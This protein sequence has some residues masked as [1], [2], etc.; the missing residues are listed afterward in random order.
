MSRRA[1]LLAFA[2]SIVIVS[3]TLPGC[4]P[5][6]DQ[7]RATLEQQ[8]AQTTVGNLR[9]TATV[10]RARMQI[11]LDFV[12]TRVMQ[13]EQAGSFL[14]ANLIALGTEGAHIDADLRRLQLAPSPSPL[15]TSAIASGAP[16]FAIATAPARTD[17]RPIVTPPATA[18]V[19]PDDIPRL[20]EIVLASGV[21]RDDCA[22]DINPV[23]TPQSEVIY[24]VAR[25][26]NIPSGV[27]LSSS[28][29]RQGAE[30]VR[31]AFQTEFPIHDNCI[32]FFIDQSDTPFN[33]GN[34]AVDIRLEDEPLMPVLPFQV[35]DGT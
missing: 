6:E 28:W 23:F 10:S 5:S 1:R 34:W 30:V 3:T 13:A 8:A 24:I 26:F 21:G 2:A 25:A 20:D 35:V 17:S 31:H 9:A 12:G 18:L 19:T 4:G 22:I 15:P 7:V 11:T 16:D 32:W 29:Q 33:A 27:R 14:R